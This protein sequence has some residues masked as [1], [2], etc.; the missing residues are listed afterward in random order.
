VLQTEIELETTEHWFMV[1][2]V[3]VKRYFPQ[4]SKEFLLEFRIF[5]LLVLVDL[6]CNLMQAW[7]DILFSLF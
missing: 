7:T 6:S 1:E 2:Y 4:L 5:G 3:I